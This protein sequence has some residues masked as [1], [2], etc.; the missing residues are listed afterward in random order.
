MP[1]IG[2]LGA[3]VTA[4]SRS[5]SAMTHVILVVEDRKD[6]SAYFPSQ[7]LMTAQE[8]L[9]GGP[10]LPAGR[11]QVINLCRN[12]RYLGPGYYCSLLAEAR[13]LLLAE[14][15]RLD[16]RR[17]ALAESHAT[18]IERASS[19]K[20]AKQLFD[21]G[22]GNQA[23][24]D[25]AR[26]AAEL[27]ARLVVEGEASDTGAEVTRFLERAAPVL[28]LELDAACPECGSA[29]TPRFD[30]ATFLAARL[31]AERP[32]L[33][34]ETHWI[35]SRYGWSHDE[36]MSLPREDRRAYAGL[37]EAERSAHARSAGQSYSLP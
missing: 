36:I 26:T 35:A 24:L 15:A 31:A 21:E 3:T 30:L 20:R 10:Q 9:D 28:D 37:V 33:V 19:L 11:V 27:L 5:E 29:G 8:Y 6:W 32:F 34:R 2:A 1:Y 25:A 22:V 18:Q 13:G 16:Q 17:A 23:D 4:P 14:R 12:Y 7:N